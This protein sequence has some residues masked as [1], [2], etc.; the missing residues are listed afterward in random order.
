LAPVWTVLTLN[1]RYDVGASISLMFETLGV[2]NFLRESTNCFLYRLILLLQLFAFIP[3]S[4]GFIYRPHV[5]R[6]CVASGRYADFRYSWFLS[7]QRPIRMNPVHITSEPQNSTGTTTSIRKYKWRIGDH[8]MVEAP[9]AMETV[10]V[11]RSINRG[12]YTVEIGNVQKSHVKCRSSQL[13]ESIAISVSKSA[14]EPLTSR[15]QQPLVSNIINLDA[16]LQN[17]ANVSNRIDDTVDMDQ[18]RYFQ[19]IKEWVVFTDLHCS[20]HT[21][22]TCV[23]VLLRVH[24]IAQERNAGILFLGDFWHIRSH[25][26]RIDCLNR[27]MSILRCHYTQPMILIPGNHDQISSSLSRDQNIHSL[28][29]LQTA[30]RIST[31]MYTNKSV[32]KTLSSVNGVLIFS[33][34]TIFMNASFIPY[35]RNP[36]ILERILLESSAS[37]SMAVFCH[38]DVT[39]ASMNDNIVS[40][41][42]ISILSFP[43]NIPIYSGHFHKPHNVTSR[44]SRENSCNEARCVEYIGSPYQVSLSE[45]HQ[46]KFIVVLNAASSWKCVDRMPIYAGRRHFHPKTLSEF[47][48][49]QVSSPKCVGQAVAVTTDENEMYPIVS[50]KPG[51]RVVFTIHKH[52][53]DA[54]RRCDAEAAG[55][56]NTESKS[57]DV[58]ISLLRNSGVA[59]EI[60]EVAAPL[61]SDNSHLFNGAIMSHEKQMHNDMSVS[62]LWS[63]FVSHEAERGLISRSHEE[64]LLCKGK[65]ILGEIASVGVDAIAS[66]MTAAATSADSSNSLSNF[67]L[68]SVTVQ[69]FGPFSEK[70]TYPLFNRGLVLLRGF[71]RDGGSDSNG[72]GKTSL[73][74]SLL[75]ALTGSVDPRPSL[76][77]KVSDVVNDSSNAAVVT[78][79]GIFNGFGFVV[80]RTK[81][82]AKGSLS[83][84]FNGDDLSRQSMKDTQDLINEKLGICSQ[85]LARTMFHGQ[86]AL[87]NLLDTTDSKL[88]DELSL[89]VPLTVWQEANVYARQKLRA[90]SKRHSELDGMILVRSEDVRKYKMR[91]EEAKLMYAGQLQIYEE[92]KIRLNDATTTLD[93]VAKIIGNAPSF[94]SCSLTELEKAARIAGDEILNIEKLLESTLLLRDSEI[95]EWE[96]KVD[97]VQAQINLHESKLRVLEQKLNAASVQEALAKERISYMQDLWKLNLTAGMPSSFHLPQICPTCQQPMSFRSDENRFAH[98]NLEATVRCDLETSFSKFSE[99][100]SSLELVRESLRLAM[101]SRLALISNLTEAQSILG[102][103]QS[104]WRDMLQPIEKQLQEAHKEQQILSSFLTSAAKQMDE[105]LRIQILEN[106][107]LSAKQALDFAAAKENNARMEWNDA[108]EVVTALKVER[109]NLTCTLRI[110]NDLCDGFGPRGIQ[111]FIMQ[112]AMAMLES[113]AQGYLDELSDGAQRLELSLNSGDCIARRAYV[114]GAN[115]VLKERPLASLSGGQWRRC[116]LAL[117]LAFADLVSNRANFRPSICVFD[118]PLLHLDQA[119]RA[120]VGRVLRNRLRGDGD[121]LNR[122]SSIGFQASTILIILQDLAADELEESFDCIDEV[123]KEWGSSTVLVDH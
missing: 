101:S 45:A 90:A 38:V 37:K 44:V 87:N 52:V 20:P 55:G 105:Q 86:H 98:D 51:D 121:R 43:P 17:P 104:H 85:V 9:A 5:C 18:L 1:Y 99:A 72:S 10:G 113:S 83:F 97:H 69:G 71:N 64:I 32:D 96:R 106:A 48:A 66:T 61:P 35:I 60:R 3:L 65:E 117:A 80:S 91:L 68:H 12:W 53:M 112:D 49:L 11:V 57:L 114:R 74:M 19:T 50:V 31:N 46:E 109:E 30:Y 27:I 2:T 115:G 88:K 67:Q 59:V 100:R 103:K 119:G 47:L 23:Q 29:P 41:G 16:Y 81:T 36:T 8:V 84:V 4:D 110:F 70:I 26:I 40:N 75:W 122:R 116:S 102:D 28:A 95:K 94:H 79:Q 89:V 7:K 42:G 111:S 15:Q 123:V 73:A 58:H 21:I 24:S 92:E 14:T 22:D 54:L 82:Q 78:V 120:S 13:R 76:D 93:S 56:E 107:V 62:S 63:A 34:P 6:G 25:S 33:Q 39:G 77:G 108:E 118:E